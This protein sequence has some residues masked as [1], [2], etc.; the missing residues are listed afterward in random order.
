LNASD[1]EN[2]PQQVASSSLEGSSSYCKVSTDFIAVNQ[3]KQE[4]YSPYSPDLAPVNFFLLGYV[5]RK[6][7]EYHAESLSEPLVLIRV[8]L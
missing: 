5:T 2:A 1:W 3:M 7:I 8:I 4:S 6:L